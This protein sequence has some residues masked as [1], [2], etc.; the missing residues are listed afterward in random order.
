[1]SSACFV[2][3][4]KVLREHYRAYRV[5]Y[6]VSGHKM[7][8]YHPGDTKSH[9][10]SISCTKAGRD[11]L[12]ESQNLLV[13]KNDDVYFANRTRA[14]FDQESGEENSDDEVDEIKDD[15]NEEKAFIINE[16]NAK[17]DADEMVYCA[18]GKEFK[19]GDDMYKLIRNYT[20][21]CAVFIDCHEYFMKLEVIDK[22]LL[23]G[24]PVVSPKF[25][26]SYLFESVAVLYVHLRK[27]VLISWPILFVKKKLSY[28]GWT[29][30]KKGITMATSYNNRKLEHS[31]KDFFNDDEMFPMLEGPPGQICFLESLLQFAAKLHFVNKNGCIEILPIIGRSRQ[32]IKAGYN[33]LIVGLRSLYDQL[34][35]QVANALK[36]NRKAVVAELKEQARQFKSLIAEMDIIV[37]D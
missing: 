33:T 28:F 30:K 36:E 12:T 15:S 19:K 7:I 14:K 35:E 17:V 16:I 27:S 34:E 20:L 32:E 8:T 18:R 13:E 3:T 37:I 26:G 5:R 6:G 29:S 4:V 25:R 9:L 24:V 10:G 31:R 1:M 2:L 21:K 22:L 11:A 23:P